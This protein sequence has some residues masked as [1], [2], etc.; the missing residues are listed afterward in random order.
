VR[1]LDSEPLAFVPGRG[2]T[3]ERSR[4]EQ[5][6]P[7]FLVPDRLPEGERRMLAAML[8]VSIVFVLLGGTVWSERRDALARTFF[9]MCLC[10]AWLLAPLRRW[11]TPG[12]RLLDQIFLTGI[13]IYLPALM[14]HFFALFPEARARGSRSVWI[15]TA[16]A[17][18]TTVF[19]PAVVVV[20]AQEMGL[21]LP[22]VA[23]ELALTVAALWFGIGLLGAL[24]LFAASYRRAMPGDARR[25]LRVALVGTLLGAAPLATVIAVRNVSPGTVIPGERWAALLT[26]LV[27]ASFAYAIMVHRIFDFRV[28]VRAASVSLLSGSATCGGRIWAR[29]SPAERSRASRWRRRSPGRPPR[30][31]APWARG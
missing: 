16:Y 6:R 13:Q 12:P 19:V 30:G 18:A 8:M 4:G 11:P 15:R 3:L 5:R 31:S 10:F 25:R 1:P 7:V 23:S 17:I 29:A 14:I 24:G 28:A 22:P 26:L 20:V 27:P 9:L 21:T 2:V